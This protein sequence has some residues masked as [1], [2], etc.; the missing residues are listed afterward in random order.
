MDS[1]QNK[2]QESAQ[3]SVQDHNFGSLIIAQHSSIRNAED[4]TT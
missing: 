4:G 1:V 3:C 2:L